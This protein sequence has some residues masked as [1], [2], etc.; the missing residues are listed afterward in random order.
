MAE[1]IDAVITRGE[2]ELLSKIREHNCRGRPVMVVV[3]TA[4]GRRSYGFSPIDIPYDLI[5]GYV[6][7]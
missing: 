1:Y 7:M 3:R 6:E 5:D 4:H 2:Q